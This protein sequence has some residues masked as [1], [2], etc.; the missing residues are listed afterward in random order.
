[1]IIELGQL[2]AGVMFNIGSTLVKIANQDKNMHVTTVK[3]CECSEWD[4]PRPHSPNRDERRFG[5]KCFPKTKLCA[6]L[7]NHDLGIGGAQFTPKEFY[8][9]RTF[10][11]ERNQKWSCDLLEE[12]RVV[13]LD[14]FPPHK[15]DLWRNYNDNYIDADGLLRTHDGMLAEINTATIPIYAQLRDDL[16]LEQPT[17]DRIFLNFKRNLNKP[18]VNLPLNTF[19]L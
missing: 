8:V 18:T 11:Y 15:W 14:W 7:K 6:L 4:M 17:V 13:Q 16:E 2:H 1:M 19:L 5:Y 9:P 10:R 12:E 3:L